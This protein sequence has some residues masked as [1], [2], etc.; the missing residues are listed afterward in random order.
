MY[1][2]LIGLAASAAI[3]L[4]SFDALACTRFIYETGT[5]TYIVGR[6]MD[7]AVDPSTDL[8]SFPRGLKRDGGAGPGSVEWTSKYGSVISSFYNIA[9]VDGMNDAGLGHRFFKMGARIVAIE[10]GLVQSAFILQEI[11]TG[12][13]CVFDRFGPD[14][15]ITGGQGR[16]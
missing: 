16:R 8:W 5:D 14:R 4:L 6:S 2:R 3:A 15:K 9:T 12:R 13:D 10:N 11:G 1:A 7:W